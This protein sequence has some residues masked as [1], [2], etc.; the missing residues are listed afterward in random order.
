MTKQK[1]MAAQA[2]TF[3]TTRMEAFSD[4]VFAIAITL[5]VLEIAV[6]AGFQDLWRA[7]VDQWASYLGYL[8]SFSTIGAVWVGHTVITEFTERATPVFIRLNLL[9]LMVVSFLPYP[10]KLM[11]EYVGEERPERVAA[12]IYG[13]NLFLTALLLSVLWRYAVR[14]GLVRSDISDHGLKMI[15]RRL[16]P[17][18]V[19]Y[20]VMILLGLF[21]PV[22]AVLGYR[23]IAVYNLIPI[24]DLR[25]RKTAA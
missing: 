16:T 9:L 20:L 17:G 18:L 14:E 7:F 6:P 15:T 11:A 24:R 8:V 3:R 4:G 10:T 25:R 23:I 1:G 13:L 21:L 22:V 12:T 19:G 5:L 2:P